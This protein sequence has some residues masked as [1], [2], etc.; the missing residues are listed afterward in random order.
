[1]NLSGVFI[2]GTDTDI[3]KTTYAR[4]LMQRHPEA[5]Y[6]KPV[7]TGAP[8]HDDTATVNAQRSL[9]GIRL[10]DPVSPH[11]A[12]ERV[13]RTLTLEEILEPLVGFEGVLVAEGAGG[14]L[15]PIAPGV[16]QTDLIAALGIPSVI[17]SR[18]VLGTINH[19]LLTIEALRTRD[20]PIAGV[21]LLGG[22]ANR[23]AIETYGGVSVI[24]DP[25]A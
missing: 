21:V 22:S 24:E 3:G 18:D 13:G 1:V 14:V 6:W 8:E 12:A 15:V 23:E 25:F 10:R 2:T 9:P 4:D 11:L 20:L 16:L 17:V 19:T 5:T 7:Q